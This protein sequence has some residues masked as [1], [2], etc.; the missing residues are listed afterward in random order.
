VS[1][2]APPEIRTI[3]NFR[4]VGG[5]AARGGRRVRTGV[6]FRSGHLGAASDEDLARLGRLGIRTVIDFRGPRDE[7]GDGARRLPPGA[8]LVRLPI[9]DPAAGGEIRD[10]LGRSDAA[11]LE[12]ILGGGG[13]E[14]MMCEAAAGLV[15]GRC[16][17]FGALLRGLAAEHRLPALMHCSA[18]KD[19]TGWAASLV[20]LVLGAS[21]DDVIEHY[22]LSNRHRREENERL[23][24]SA[25][26][27]LDPEWIRPFLEVRV[28][29][30][31][32]ALDAV[33][34][35][36]GSFEAY[37]ETGLGVDGATVERLRARFVE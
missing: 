36:F 33:A 25:R 7:A 22:L 19:R 2:G 6:L 3:G 24:A 5:C 8:R 35:R 31:R 29:Y 9:G 28:E 1:R 26:D 15:T 32:A 20:L 4:D 37:V 21:E 18:G 13:A 30:A 10:L 11:G 23:L 17:E 14:R 12:R 34:R 27:G 16:A